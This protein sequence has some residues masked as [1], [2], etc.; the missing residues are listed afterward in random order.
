MA[1]RLNGVNQYMDLGNNIDVLNDVSG[2]TLMA[3]IKPNNLGSAGTQ[4]YAGF[5]FGPGTGVPTLSSRL[6]LEQTPG[7]ST[8]R[9]VARSLDADVASTIDSTSV[10]LDDQWNHIAVVASF[11]NATGRFYINGA[12]SN[13]STYA[14][15][16]LGNTSNTNV[17]NAAIGA[18]ENGASD[19]YNGE[20]EDIRLY[21]RVLSD[22]EMSTIFANHG[23]D[24]I[25]SGLVLR[26]LC[27]ELGVGQ[28]VAQIVSTAGEGTVHGRTATP[29]NGPV[30][31]QPGVLRYRSKGSH[32]YP[33]P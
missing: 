18:Q 5:S 9:S 29:V 25:V 10:P 14:V 11:A 20:I 19:F 4:V 17:R 7:A 30:T 1:I 33:P 22:G 8:L 26:F 12:L 27:N 2:A 3:W 32:R 16:T 6:S 21:E 31:Y 15:M 24:G 23:S 13:Q 28:T